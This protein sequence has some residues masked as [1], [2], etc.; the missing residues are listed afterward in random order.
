MRRIEIFL[1]KRSARVVSLCVLC[2]LSLTMSGFVQGLDRD[3][4]PVPFGD[5]QKYMDF[6][7]S[8]GGGTSSGGS[9]TM[10]G[11]IGQPIVGVC[12]GGPYVLTSGFLFNGTPYV[13]PPRPV[14]PEPEPEPE[15]LPL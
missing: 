8:G 14:E 2:C 3:G 10:T 7:I 15:P 9:F 11:T 5:K 13:T 6:L 1:I 12:S 4:S